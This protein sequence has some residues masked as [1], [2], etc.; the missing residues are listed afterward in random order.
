MGFRVDDHETA[1]ATSL[2]LLHDLPDA[3][4]APPDT[5]LFVAKLNPVT[6]DREMSRKARFWAVGRGFGAHFQPCL[7]DFDAKS[8]RKS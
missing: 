8:R 7:G 1:K 3:E 2:E 6:Q 4:I 5:D